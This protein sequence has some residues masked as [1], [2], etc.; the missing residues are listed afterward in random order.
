MTDFN[1]LSC[2]SNLENTGK[3]GCDQAISGIEYVCFA[4]LDQEFATKAAA[5]TEATWQT[6]IQS[7]DIYPFFQ[8]D[9]TE[10]QSTED[11][12]F[13]GANGLV[14]IPTSKGRWVAKFW[15]QIPAYN[16]TRLYSFGGVS[17]RMYMADSQGQVMGTTEDGTKMRGLEFRRLQVSKPKLA[18]TKDEVMRVAITIEFSKIDEYTKELAV[19]SCDFI[20]SIEGLVD[21]DVAYVST[22]AAFTEHTVTVARECDASAVSGLVVGDFTLTNDASEVQAISSIAESATVAGTYVLTTSALV[23]DSYIV[24]LNIPTV[25]TTEGYESTGSATFDID[26]A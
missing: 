6:D 14:V 18:L 9:E 1:S 2:N 3:C 8:I 26:T 24:N 12:T 5:E 21:V 4:K 17:G 11:G 20:D 10:D 23:T 22:N 13:S 15:M 25:M 7:K 19:A 16:L